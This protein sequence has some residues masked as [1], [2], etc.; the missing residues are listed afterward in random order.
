MR[1]MWRLLDRVLG[2]LQFPIEVIDAEDDWYLECDGYEI[3]AFAT[4]HGIPSL[5][6]RLIEPDRPGTFDIEAARK[7]GVPE[8]P[9]FGR[10]QRGESV[11]G[12]G[13]T[14]VT[15]E[16]VLGEA[17]SGR[18]VVYSGDT[19][20]TERTRDAARN[21]SVLVHEATF[22]VDEQVR[23][24]QTAHATA[25]DAALLGAAANVDMLLLTHISNRYTG[26][27]ISEEA[28]EV[29]PNAICVNDFDLVEIP[30]PERGEP[31][32]IRKGARPPRRATV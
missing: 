28:Q 9:L 8:G 19:R 23:A 24:D 25:R 4:D 10:L 18:L 11:E 6:Y 31:R 20:A 14:T 12:T 32:Y 5:G 3:D 22:C 27:D 13:G 29:F 17:R 26:R 16:D 7:L 15:P 2:R 1:A 30:F 21:A